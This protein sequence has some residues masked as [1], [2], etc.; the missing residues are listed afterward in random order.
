MH[1]EAK[2]AGLREM[3]RAGWDDGRGAL[4]PKFLAIVNKT[5]APRQVERMTRLHKG[6]I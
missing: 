5:A 2:G 4:F 6:D 3:R 1:K